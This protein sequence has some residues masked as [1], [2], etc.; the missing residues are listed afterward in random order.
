MTFLV[1]ALNSKF[2]NNISFPSKFQS[3]LRSFK[4]DGILDN[5]DCKQLYPSSTN[6]PAMYGLPKIHKLAVPL[7]PIFSAISKLNLLTTLKI[8]VFETR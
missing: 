7:R 6:T 5:D 1:I 4:A 8:N 2:A 3:F